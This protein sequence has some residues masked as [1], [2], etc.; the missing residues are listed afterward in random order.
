MT[1]LDLAREVVI[2]RKELQPSDLACD[3]WRERGLSADS[4]FKTAASRL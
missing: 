4:V 1:G 3:R 2:E